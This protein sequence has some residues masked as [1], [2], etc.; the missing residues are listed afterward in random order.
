MLKAQKRGSGRG[1]GAC[2]A[3]KRSYRL[4]GIEQRR[5]EIIRE[6]FGLIADHLY[7][8]ALPFEIHTINSATPACIRELGID[9]PTEDWDISRFVNPPR[10]W[11]DIA[12][13]ALNAGL[14]L[15]FDV[16]RGLSCN[17]TAMLAG[18]L[19]TD[20]SFGTDVCAAY[21]CIRKRLVLW[22]RNEEVLR[23]ATTDD[24]AERA[25]VKGKKE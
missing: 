8:P 5:R 16:P 7:Q 11:I 15:S 6:G 19:G 12:N 17:L 18:R 3:P 22:H 25:S 4:D 14:R 9:D 10:C 1:A 24:L 13:Q 2:K 21:D 20:G 23:D